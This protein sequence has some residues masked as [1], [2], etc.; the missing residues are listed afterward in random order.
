[1]KPRAIAQAALGAAMVAAGT[2][3]LTVQREEF[4]NQ[5]PPWVPIS[6]D[7]TV[8]LSGVVPQI[9]II[10]GPCAGGAAYS[11]A[12]TDFIIQTRKAHMFITG[13]DVIKTVTGEDVTLEDLG[14]ARAHNSRSGVAHFM[15]DD[16]DEALEDIPKA[17][18][19]KE[20]LDLAQHIIDTKRGDFDPEGFDDRY[21]EA[22]V[23]L[24][25]A[26]VEGRKIPKAKPRAPAKIMDLRE[27]LRRSA[28]TPAP[29]PPAR[30]RA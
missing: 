21:E 19:E 22:F 10:A 4:Q 3:H 8:L 9:A 24:I 16:E 6:E 12:L 13:P 28:E 30:K 14:G 26:K 20:L 25:R 1:M 17:R 18:I 29:D 2:G 11:P 23:A 5:V 15:S 7:L 27:A